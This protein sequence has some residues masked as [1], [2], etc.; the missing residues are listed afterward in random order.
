[1]PVLENSGEHT[2]PTKNSIFSPRTAEWIYAIQRLNTGPIKEKLNQKYRQWPILS[3]KRPP[4]HAQRNSNCFY[5]LDHSTSALATIQWIICAGK[6]GGEKQT[7]P[8]SVRPRNATPSC[9][10][11]LLTRSKQEFVLS[12]RARAE[13]V[14]E[15][16]FFHRRRNSS[17]SLGLRTNSK[18]LGARSSKGRASQGG[19]K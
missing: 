9:G 4:T 11:Q 10:V 17:S 3:E 18:T 14:G 6:N 16:S 5:N 8:V 19:K 15:G 13:L 7:E 1:M 12:G 2:E